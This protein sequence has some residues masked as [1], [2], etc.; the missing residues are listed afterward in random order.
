MSAGPGGEESGMTPVLKDHSFRAPWGSHHEGGDFMLSLVCC[1]DAFKRSQ[2]EDTGCGH[3][4]EPLTGGIGP[5]GVAAAP[6]L[7][8][9]NSQKGMTGG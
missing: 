6:D 8:E 2:V 7:E 5:K 9:I 4:S 1:W 3:S